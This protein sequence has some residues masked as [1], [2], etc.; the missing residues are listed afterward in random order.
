MS[1]SKKVIGEFVLKVQAIENE[2]GYPEYIQGVKNWNI[3]TEA[4]I[5]Q[6]KSLVKHLEDTYFKDF[7]DG[8]GKD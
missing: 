3:Q 1:D 6:I 8:L 4:V 2:Y 7:K 5:M